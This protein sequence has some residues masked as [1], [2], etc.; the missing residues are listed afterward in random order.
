V[1]RLSAIPI[2]TTIEEGVSKGIA[3]HYIGGPDQTTNGS[4]RVLTPATVRVI[5]MVQLDSL[6]ATTI[7]D[8]AAIDT[9]L[10]QAHATVTDGVVLNCV[11][12]NAIYYSRREADGR[13]WQYIGGA[14]RVTVQGS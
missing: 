1:S 10:H 12:E 5:L 13:T 6:D 9:A 2:E 14:Y 8:S 3:I 7:A 4:D 11:R